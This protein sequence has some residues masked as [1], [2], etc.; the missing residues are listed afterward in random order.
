[1]KETK[2]GYN[3]SMPEMV[4]ELNENIPAEL[5]TINLHSDGFDIRFDYDSISNKFIVTIS[6]GVSIKM[7]G[8]AL[9]VRLQFKE[10]KILRG[11]TVI[12]SPFKPNM[13]R[14]TV[15]YV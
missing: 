9:A 15:L 5:K 1:M 4:A 7:Q 2:P 6:H 14:Y 13:K 3:S 8:S 12:V 11:T 10:N